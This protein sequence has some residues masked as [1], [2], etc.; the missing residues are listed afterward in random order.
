VSIS[1]VK[2]QKKIFFKQLWTSLVTL[3]FREPFPKLSAQGT[4]SVAPLRIVIAHTS[5]VI[6]NC[7]PTARL[8]ENQQPA[9]HAGF[10]ENDTRPISFAFHAGLAYLGVRFH[11]HRDFSK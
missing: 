5:S 3:R 9:A 2:V 10:P 11:S 6:R 4:H 8:S 1:F 7:A